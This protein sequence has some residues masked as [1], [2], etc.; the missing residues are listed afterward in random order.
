MPETQQSPT[1]WA[2]RFG[3]RSITRPSPTEQRA[4]AAVEFAIA[5][6]RGHCRERPW[7]KR[8]RPF[9]LPSVGA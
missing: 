2:K 7:L 3:G 9:S 5:E 1:A 8:C 4:C 6:R